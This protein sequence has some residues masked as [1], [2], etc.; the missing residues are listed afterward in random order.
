MMQNPLESEY[1]DLIKNIT[2][3]MAGPLY[4]QKSQ[5]IFY[6]YKEFYMNHLA[7]FL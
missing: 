4:T 6:K 3:I 1:E 5:Y 7:D 2:I